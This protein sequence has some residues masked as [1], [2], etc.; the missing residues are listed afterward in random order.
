MD[1]SLSLALLAVVLPVMIGV[2]VLIKLSMGGPILFRHRQ[3]GKG[4][5]EFDCLKFRTMENNIRE[6]QF[7]AL[8]TND[9]AAREEWNT[10][11]K[12]R[13]DPRITS[14]GHVLRKYSIDELPQLFNILNG[15]MSLVGPRPIVQEEASFYGQ[16]FTTYCS[17]YPGLTGLWQ[18]SGRNDVD[19]A[20]RV[21][22][23]VHYIQSWSPAQDVKIILKTLPAVLEARGCY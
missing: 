8:L 16:H 6:E 20:L 10:N 14:L 11:H 21:Q 15:E 18:I 1:I 22:L 19:Y 4:G 17:V 5:R 7:T 3:I 12:L 23:D 13:D 9:P 2:A